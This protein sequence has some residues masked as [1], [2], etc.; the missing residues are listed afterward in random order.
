MKTVIV[1]GGIGG[2]LSALLLHQNGIDVMIVE[3]RDRLGGRLAFIEQD[4]YKIDEGPTIVLLPEMITELLNEAG[5]NRDDYELI[6]IDPLYKIHFHDGATYEKY[7]DQT[8]QL[9]ELRR[10]YPEEQAGYLNFMKD[11]D[12][13]FKLGMDRFIKRS[14]VQKK[15]F[16]SKQN[17]KTLLKL[18]A[19]RS[20]YQSLKTYFKEEN[21]RL[22]YSLQSLYIGGNPYESPA[23]YSLISYSEHKHGIYYLKGGYASL[24]DVLN[25]EIEKSGIKVFL[26][27]EVA[28]LTFTR[29]RATGVNV[30]GQWIKADSVIL[31]GDYPVI[32]TLLDP[33]KSAQR[34]YTP[35]SSCLL[36]YFGLDKIY[37]NTPVHQFFMGKDF[38][39]HMSEVFEEKVVPNDPAFYTFHPS[40]I[41]STLAPEGKGV[42]YVL[43]PVPAGSHIEWSTKQSFVEGIIDSL[44]KRGYPDLRQHIVWQ[45]VRTPNDAESEGIFQ[46]G[47]FGIA[48]ILFQSGVFRPQAKPSRYEN[49][50]A[51]GASV[52]PGGGIPIVMQGARLMVEQLLQDAERRKKEWSM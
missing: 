23:L 32:S 34:S 28:S 10:L 6:R 25:R 4:D 29:N 18:K 27:S 8:K 51:V 39:S 44:E 3:K 20:V 1:G 12:V 47:S 17:I 38:S 13:H 50:Y 2:L 21:L 30:N 19:Y 31:N 45:K 36:L 46:G 24:V 42:L 49:V 43:V 16:W 11:M 22:A 33:S 37:E 41:D 5:I 26:N 14:F 48:P 35:S 52:H 15:D 9:N 7:S 40:V